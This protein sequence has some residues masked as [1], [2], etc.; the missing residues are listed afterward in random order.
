[1][2][3]L[4]SPEVHEVYLVQ[5]ESGLLLGSY[6]KEKNTD[7]DVIAGMLTAIKS[8][9]E[10]AF[11]RGKEDLEMIQYE[12]Y[13]KDLITEAELNALLKEIPLPVD[14]FTSAKT[15]ENVE[16]LFKDF[17]TEIVG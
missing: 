15:G 12:N 13:K 4:D 5:R 10:D 8:F 2:S 7:Q 6:A 11:N 14:L 17:A 9:A 16:K 3:Q 1:L